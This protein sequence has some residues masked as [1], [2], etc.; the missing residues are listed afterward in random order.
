MPR[1]NNQ[2]PD[3]AARRLARRMVERN[4]P[5][6]MGQA[7]A[8]NSAKDDTATYFGATPKVNEGEVLMGD[9]RNRIYRDRSWLP[10]SRGQ[11]AIVPRSL[12]D[13]GYNRGGYAL[14]PGYV[15]SDDPTPPF[16]PRGS[17][18]VPTIGV[19]VAPPIPQPGTPAGWR[20]GGMRPELAGVQPPIILPVTR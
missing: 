14:P 6:G 4:V 9:W 18:A 10:Q 19:I 3:T 8:D 2:T 11:V 16:T 1:Y 7:Y 5:A 15:F 17:A 20:R 12:M 13:T